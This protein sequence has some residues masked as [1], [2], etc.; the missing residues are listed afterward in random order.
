LGQKIYFLENFEYLNGIVN[1]DDVIENLNKKN[2]IEVE[3]IF[4]KLKYKLDNFFLND[5]SSLKYIVSPTTGITHIDTEYTST[6]NIKIISLQG[7][8]S[9]LKDVPSTAEMT[10]LLILQIIRNFENARQKVLNG[11]WQRN[12]IPGSNIK[13]LRVL[14]IGY[15]RVGKQVADILNFFGAE[16]YIF[17]TDSNTKNTNNISL[18]LEQLKEIKFD[19]VTI[20]VNFSAENEN[21]FDYDFFAKMQSGFSL[22]NTARGELICHAG[23]LKLLNEER[24]KFCALDVLPQEPNID[25]KLLNALQAFGER[26]CITPH[27]AGFTEG[28]LKMVEEKVYSKYLTTKENS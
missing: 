17:D 12:A 14:I 2:I 24:V 20:H 5:F 19:I 16:V 15:G 9:F 3:A 22:V 6:K 4:V 8:N 13:D 7:E 11:K 10:L 26:I 28:S 21:Y 23:L 25:I 27:V 1:S 18:S